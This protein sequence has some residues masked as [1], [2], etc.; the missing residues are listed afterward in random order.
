MSDS[1]VQLWE[2][3][4]ATV[5]NAEVEIQMR[6]SR[7]GD[8]TKDMAKRKDIRNPEA[9]GAFL[10]RKKHGKSHFQKKAARARHGGGAR[11]NR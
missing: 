11:R 10:G 8:F 7:G 5:Q 2:D 6:Q 9:L 4:L 3:V 1:G